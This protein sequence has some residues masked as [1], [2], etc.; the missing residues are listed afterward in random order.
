MGEVL[1]KNFD[2]EHRWIT[3]E[4]CNPGVMIDAMFF[5]SNAEKPDD[6]DASVRYKS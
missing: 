2:G 6:D 5:A 3:D 1:Q 4:E